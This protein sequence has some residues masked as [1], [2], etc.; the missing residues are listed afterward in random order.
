M[1]NSKISGLTAATTPLAGTEELALLQTSDKRITVAN[2]AAGAI[3]SNATTGVM[4]ITGPAAGE[5]RIA[6]VPNAN[7]TVARTDVEQT[8]MESQ[9]VDGNV[10]L[11]NGITSPRSISFTNSGGTYYVGVD[12]NPPII[13]DVSYSLISY[14]PLGKTIRQ[15]IGGTG[16]ITV[17]S[18]T[19]FAIMGAL[20]KSLGSF[21]IDHPLPALVETHQ[22]VHSFIEGPKADL[23]YRGKATLVNG[24]VFVN[25]DEASTMTEGTFVA[26]CRE[27]QCFTTNESDWTAV[28]GSVN[29][30][31]LTIK[32]Q[33]NTSTASISWMVIGERQDKH[34]MD[35]EWT[36]DNGKVIVEPL[37][38]NLVN[39]NFGNA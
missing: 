4:Q 10:L 30:N 8:F 22:L 2:F 12:G 3:K 36:D 21:R 26:L 15:Y 20:S 13:G 28:K 33:D 29:G 1:A 16:A 37:K 18:S 25:I 5:V 27:V 6:T 23:I 9:N 39:I 34:M 31:I 11:T 24:E 19:G 32:A 7:F 17:T 14:A 35:T 38:E